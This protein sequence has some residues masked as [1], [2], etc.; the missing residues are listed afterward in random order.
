M[1]N[2]PDTGSGHAEQTARALLDAL[3]TM[4]PIPDLAASV[5]AAVGV[6]PAN[7]V[8]SGL[9]GYHISVGY[10]TA[11]VYLAT[12]RAFALYEAN[13]R[14]ESYTLTVPIERV[15]RIGR[16]E[17]ATRTRLVIELEADRGSASF[18]M[19]E[20]GE[21][22]GTLI[23]AGYE[24]LEEEPAGRDRLRSFAT[25]LAQAVAGT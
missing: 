8:A 21:I 9:T 18:T 12:P 16:L 5:A 6:T 17:D 22:A 10:E 4:P 1:G 20:N 23:P 15:R 24:L 2:A 7:L 25:A 19:N 14:G 3:N 11:A 13:A